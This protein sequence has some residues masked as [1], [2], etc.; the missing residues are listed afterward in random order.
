MA[1]RR[2]LKK[3]INMMGADLLQECLAVKQT[4]PTIK[5]ADVENIAMSILLMQNDFVNRLSHVDKRQVRRFFAQ[6]QDDLEVSKNELIDQIYH[7]T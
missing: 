1:K 4:H 5:D 2:E 6:L 3:V 7:L